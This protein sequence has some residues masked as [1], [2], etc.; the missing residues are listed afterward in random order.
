MPVSKAH[1]KLTTF[2]RKYKDGDEVPQSDLLK[3]MDWSP[4][5]LRT[6]ESKNKI[7]PFL[8]R[9]NKKS[10][11][12]LQNGNSIK[13]EEV[14]KYFTQTSPKT[15]VFTQGMNLRATQGS[16]RLVEKLGAGAVGHVWSAD[17]MG[18]LF[19]LKVLQPRPDLLDPS[20]IHNV[21]DRFRREAKNGTIIHHPNVIAYHDYGDYKGC[22]FL[23]MELAMS[24]LANQL[25]KIGKFSPTKSLNIVLECIEGL[26]H[27]HSQ[28]C[29][30]RD[31]KP[32]NI[33]FTER[34]YVLGDLGI[35]R[36]N[37]FHPEFTSAGTLTR[38]SVQLG[39]WYYMAPEQS[40][41]PSGSSYPSDVYALGITWFEILTGQAPNPQAVSAMRHGDACDLL[42]I[43]NLI[44]RMVK[45]E[46]KDRPLLAELKEK[47]KIIKN[48]FTD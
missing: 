18:K 12:A 28:N 22:P 42:E 4:S 2:L 41:D 8:V 35:V 14:F 34:G 26:E 10:F 48:I 23:V 7:A 30:H 6:Y 20:H 13:S 39:S 40:I 16:Y 21:C 9:I 46:P 29:I 32:A 11:K 15:I 27:L 45:Y 17:R 5:T 1:E 31:I 38:A 25:Q 44:N 3:A 47:I 33:L 37:E 19:A 36:W 43:N 24:S